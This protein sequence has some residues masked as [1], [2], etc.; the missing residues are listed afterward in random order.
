MRIRV[1]MP[2]VVLAAT[3]FLAGC[4][5]EQQHDDKHRGCTGGDRDGVVAA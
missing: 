4:G 3:T 1:V 5:R 2:S